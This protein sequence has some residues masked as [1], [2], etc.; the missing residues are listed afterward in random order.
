M[1]SI[2]CESPGCSNK[3]TVHFTELKGGGKESESHLCDQCA[4]KQGV[5]SFQQ[6]N[7][8]QHLLAQLEIGESG[9]S[10]QD[11]TACPRCGLT[12]SEFRLSGRLGCTHDYEVFRSELLAL[13]ERVHEA[14][15]HC[16]KVPSHAGEAGRRQRELQTLNEKLKQAVER[17]DYECAAELRDHIR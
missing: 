5:T 9:A 7:I 17:E 10:T 12:L 6:H 2:Q 3:A 14:T 4:Q 13:I 16:G 11:E 8:M 1:S 15:E